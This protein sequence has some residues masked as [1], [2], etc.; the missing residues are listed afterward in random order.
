MFGANIHPWSNCYRDNGVLIPIIFLFVHGED[1]HCSILVHVTTTIHCFWLGFVLL[2][3]SLLLYLLF[4]FFFLARRAY[5]PYI[6]SRF[7]HLLSLCCSLYYRLSLSNASILLT[8]LSGV[9]S[10]LCSLHD[11][12]VVVQVKTQVNQSVIILPFVGYLTR[13]VPCWRKV[14][15]VQKHTHLSHSLSLSLLAYPSGSPPQI[16]QCLQSSKI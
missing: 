3:S 10:S 12:V 1:C 2:G 8:S 11:L 7:S 5:I 13:P 15:G 4:T 16:M 9:L 14:K 6:L